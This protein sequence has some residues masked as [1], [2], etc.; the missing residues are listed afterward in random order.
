MISFKAILGILFA[1]LVAAIVVLGAIS[2]QYS[3]ETVDASLL[4]NRTHHAIENAGEIS[5]TFRDVL[6][7]SNAFYFK[8][9]TSR[10]HK[11]FD[12]RSVLFAQIANLRRLTGDDAEQQRNIDS[13]EL[14]VKD[15]VTFTK[16]TLAFS[17]AG[18]EL[19][20]GVES[21]FDKSNVLRKNTNSMLF[22]IKERQR[23]LLQQRERAYQRS[24]ASFNRTYAQ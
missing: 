7:E 8:S 18:M 24:V 1:L 21:R 6:L 13:L 10:S 20:K 9:D 2:Y 4:I 5:A 23:T 15:L 19:K 17:Y 16:P 22:M 12:V 3:A 14:L 11:Y